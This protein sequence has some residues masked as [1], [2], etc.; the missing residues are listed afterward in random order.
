MINR[1]YSNGDTLFMSDSQKITTKKFEDEIRQL[2]RKILS[3]STILDKNI[4]DEEGSYIVFQYKIDRWKDEKAVLEVAGLCLLG[5]RFLADLDSAIR[6]YSHCFDKNGWRQ[7]CETE[8]LVKKVITLLTQYNPTLSFLLACMRSYFELLPY[9]VQLFF[10][11]CHLN[12]TADVIHFAMTSKN[13]YYIFQNNVVVTLLRHS[14]DHVA[15][16][17]Y[18]AAENIYLKDTNILRKKGT[19]SYHPGRYRYVNQTQFQIALRNEEYDEVEKMEEYLTYEEKQKQ[20]Y[21]V[22]PDGEIKSYGC[23]FETVKLLLENLVNVINVDKVI[24]E[25]NPDEMTSETRIALQELH[26]AV[27]PENYHECQIGLVFDARIYL[28]AIN[29]IPQISNRYGTW[30]RTTFWRIRVQELIASCLSTSYLS[31]HTHGV[32]YAI[33]TGVFKKMTRRG[34]KI[35]T[36]NSSYFSFRRSP[37]FRPGFHFYVSSTGD[38]ATQDGSYYHAIVGQSVE[39]LYREKTASRNELMRKYSRPEISA[40]YSFK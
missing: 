16:G 15:L 31:R 13:S 12:S 7:E 26:N 2:Y 23:D 21:E 29:L 33:Y 8:I 40:S 19:T 30:H 14:L 10:M 28:Q 37:D 38:R 27:N 11:I 20:F 34:C 18:I 24:N 35:L 25:N 9:E 32:Y 36:D 5:E 22:F 39:K 17:E 3:Y 1:A 4:K 6:D